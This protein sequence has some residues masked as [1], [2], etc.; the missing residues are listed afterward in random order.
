[1]LYGP[2]RN[3]PTSFLLNFREVFFFFQAWRLDLP[4]GLRSGILIPTPPCYKLKLEVGMPADDAWQDVEDQT[5]QC[6]HVSMSHSSQSFLFCI[7]WR[8]ATFPAIFPHHKLSAA[9][10]QKAQNCI[11]HSNSIQDE[12]W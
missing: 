1:M 11:H 10:N 9:Q 12:G 6:P 7:D 4:T 2:P 8:F 3:P 5:T